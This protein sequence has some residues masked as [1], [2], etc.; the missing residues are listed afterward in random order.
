M[1]SWARSA[2]P[3]RAF[4]VGRWVATSRVTA[5]LAAQRGDVVEVGGGVGELLDE[6]GQPIDRGAQAL[7]LRGWLPRRPSGASGT[8][9]RC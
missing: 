5:G 1:V 6:L 4:W 9:H 7:V 3:P 8:L 2:L